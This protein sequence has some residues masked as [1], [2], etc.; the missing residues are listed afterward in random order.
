MTTP[1]SWPPQNYKD[2]SQ[3]SPFVPT[4]RDRTYNALRETM[5]KK[6][7]TLREIAKGAGVEHGWLRI[8]AGAGNIPDPSVSRIE[9]L[10]HYLVG[11][12]L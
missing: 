3:P 6:Q 4:L 10:Y 11:V 7:T 1:D 2:N 8:F 12:K 5:A 9:R